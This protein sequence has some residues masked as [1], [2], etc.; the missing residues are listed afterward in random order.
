MLAYRKSIYIHLEEV[1]S[2]V[3]FVSYLLFQVDYFKKLNVRVS[4][5]CRNA[6]GMHAD[7]VRIKSSRWHHKLEIT[8]KCCEYLHMDKAKIRVA[9]TNYA[10]GSFV[11]ED[12]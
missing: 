3:N 7:A 2:H 4:Q 8:S 1:G 12:F 5:L 9:L 11:P 10:R 6:V